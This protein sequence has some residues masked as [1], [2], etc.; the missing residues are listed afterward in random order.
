MALVENL[1]ARPIR[2]VVC[3]IKPLPEQG[4]GWEAVTVGEMVPGGMPPGTELFYDPRE[5]GR[6]P[7]VRLGKKYGLKFPIPFASHPDA[8]MKVRFTDDA[9]LHWEIDPDLHLSHPAGPAW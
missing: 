7:L 2:D 1:S 3:R 5:G 9:G 6:V 4:F 8:Q